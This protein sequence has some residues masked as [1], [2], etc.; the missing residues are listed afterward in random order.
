MILQKITEQRVQYSQ[1]EPKDQ[2]IVDIEMN[3]IQSMIRIT[4]R[5]L[6][7]KYNDDEESINTYYNVV[8]IHKYLCHVRKDI[9]ESLTNENS[10]LKRYVEDRSRMSDCIRLEIPVQQQCKESI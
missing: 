4:E 8:R 9:N 2:T 6:S 7:V 5:L 3:R 10:R 1:L